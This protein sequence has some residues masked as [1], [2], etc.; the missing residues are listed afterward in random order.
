M[1][2]HM[3]NAGTMYRSNEPALVPDG[4]DLGDALREAVGALPEGIYRAVET[5]VTV[6]VTAGPII[7][8]DDAWC[9]VSIGLWGYKQGW[10]NNGRQKNRPP[11]QRRPIHLT[12]E[13]CQR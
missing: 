6:R 5:N 2:G 8:P 10:V 7:V 11:D 13:D 9:A 3:A 4:R 1:L 12:R